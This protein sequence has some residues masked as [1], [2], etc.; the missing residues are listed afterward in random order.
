MYF[1]C[2]VGT[3]QLAGKNVTPSTKR[4]PKMSLSLFY[5]YND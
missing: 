3:A 2:R 1:Y 4:S 5:L